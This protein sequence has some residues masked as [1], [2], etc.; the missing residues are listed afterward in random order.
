MDS[1]A[2]HLFIAV[3]FFFVMP[4]MAR[5]QADVAGSKD[6]PL[7]SRWPGYYINTYDHKK[8]DAYTYY[9]K[10]G[11]ET[12]EGERYHLMYYCKQGV[13]PASELEIIRNYENAIRKAG[14]TVLYTQ[15]KSFTVGKIVKEG[16]EVWVR[17][18]WANY[19]SVIV[20]DIVER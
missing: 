5:A 13:E 4:P 8:F 10:D 3:L 1:K 6:Y 2:H 12:V 18:S 15:G 7:F 19:G 9:L 20:L 17:A 11:Q 14:G 16:K